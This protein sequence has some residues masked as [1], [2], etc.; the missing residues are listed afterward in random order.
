LTV[1]SVQRINTVAPSSGTPSCVIVILLGD[2]FGKSTG[3]DLSPPHPPNNIKERTIIDKKY[4]ILVF[5]VM[6]LLLFRVANPEHLNHQH[7]TIFERS[8]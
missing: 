5:L 2:S 4:L 6:L 3:R 7:K 8:F 1:E